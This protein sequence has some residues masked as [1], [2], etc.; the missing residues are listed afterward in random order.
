MFTG[1]IEAVG[2]LI[3]KEKRGN[4]YTVTVK[5]PSKFL[6]NDRV[7]IGDSVA[8]NGVCLTVTSINAN[9][10]NADIS[11]ETAEHTCFNSYK[12]GQRLNL[13]LACTPSTHLGGHIVQGHIDGTGEIILV[14]QASESFDVYIRS[15]EQLMC[16]IAKKGSI[17]VDGISLTVNDVEKDTFRLTLI[18]HTRE[19][20][21]S[22]L[23]TVGHMVN[24]EVDVLARY[25]ER[26]M[27][28]KHNVNKSSP[29]EF[30]GDVKTNSKETNGFTLE[31]LYKNGFI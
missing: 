25:L 7:K 23:F 4:G 15:P 9:T 17:A 20:V 24:I 13:E 8:N 21:S 1:I 19:Q 3:N 2:T 11:Y 14:K 16:Y 31:N 27:M 5:V 18:K 6:L 30:S 22:D 12:I 28:F 29:Y 26:L 10:F